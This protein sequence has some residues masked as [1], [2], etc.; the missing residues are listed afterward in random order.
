ML[1]ETKK[2]YKSLGYFMKVLVSLCKINRKGKTEGN[3]ETNWV[4]V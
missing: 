2:T 4:L 3:K 1:Q